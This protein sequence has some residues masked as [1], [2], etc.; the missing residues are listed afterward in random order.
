[1]HAMASMVKSVI[2]CCLLGTP[3]IAQKADA[4]PEALQQMAAT[5]RAF[6][7]RALVIG[8]KDAF[9]EYF[10]NSAVGF[11][12]GQAAP[13]REQIRANPDPPPGMQLVW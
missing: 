12:K 9:L 10:S 5:E 11:E 2:V 13:A 8:W 6:A 4:L 1:M 3:L 7:A